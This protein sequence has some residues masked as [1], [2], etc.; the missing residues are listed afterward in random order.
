MFYQSALKLDLKMY[1]ACEAFVRMMFPH[2]CLSVSLKTSF[3]VDAECNLGVI[4]TC[5][6]ILSRMSVFV[7]ISD[8]IM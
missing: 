6:R 1:C 8:T 2:I 5:V 4:Y 3:I 7:S